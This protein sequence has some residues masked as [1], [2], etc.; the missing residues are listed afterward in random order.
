M[1]VCRIEPFDERNHRSFELS[2]E[3]LFRHVAQM[4]NLRALLYDRNGPYMPANGASLFLRFVGSCKTLTKLRVTY[5]DTDGIDLLKAVVTSCP[6]LVYASLFSLSAKGQIH[7][8]MLDNFLFI[9]LSLLPPLFPFPGIVTSS[10]S[11]CI[12][13][14]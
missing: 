2:A 4:G 5:L 14:F 6:Q 3:G 13:F 12:P 9:F 1:G 8:A 11:R 7:F 10:A